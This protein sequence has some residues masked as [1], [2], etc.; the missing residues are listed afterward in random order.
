MTIGMKNDIILE[1]MQSLYE[2]VVESVWALVVVVAGLV[3]ESLVVSRLAGVVNS[4][5][6]GGSVGRD[7]AVSVVAV[8]NVVV[9]RGVVI[10][11][12]IHEYL[13]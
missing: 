12:N 1:M 13:F 5:V 8:S 3:D 6:V 4:L 10:A 9:V 2:V 11:G 7:V